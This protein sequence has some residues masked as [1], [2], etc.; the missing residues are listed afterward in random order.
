VKKIKGKAIR[1]RGCR[2]FLAGKVT[3]AFHKRK[4]KRISDRQGKGK[5]RGRRE[6]GG[7]SHKVRKGEKVE[8]KL[9]R[10]PIV[11]EKKGNL[12]NRKTKLKRENHSKGG[13][14][15]F[16]K[17]NLLAILEI[18][19]Q[20]RKQFSDGKIKSSTGGINIAQREIGNHFPGV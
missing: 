5:A 10:S 2:T 9:R 19:S 4:K 18:P 11:V 20:K 13:R 3:V 7:G 1:R 15:K 6:E 8:N 16:S 14:K 12:L 17:Q